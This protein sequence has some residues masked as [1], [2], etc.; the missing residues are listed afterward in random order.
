MQFSRV[1]F[2]Y[3]TQILYGMLKHKTG[4]GVNV[5]AR[6]GLCL[7]LKDPSIP[8]PEEFDETGMEILPSILFGDNENLYMALMLDRLSKDGLDPKLYLHKMTRA[9]F[10]RG[11]AALFPRIN[12]LSDFNDIIQQEQK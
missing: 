3:R 10:N 2:S 5:L 9:H 7:S 4:L 6:Y 11:A 8:N 12:D 1:R